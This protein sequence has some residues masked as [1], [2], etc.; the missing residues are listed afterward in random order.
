M[1][2]PH[3]YWYA[4]I[5]PFCATQPTE[6]PKREYTLLF[7]KKCGCSYQQRDQFEKCPS[8]DESHVLTK[9]SYWEK[10]R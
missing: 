2:C 5:C 4:G 8:G 1:S 9:P 3:G 6:P 7:C 10:K